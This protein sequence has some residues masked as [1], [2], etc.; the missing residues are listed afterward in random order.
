MIFALKDS[1]DR[2]SYNKHKGKIVASTVISSSKH[3][4]PEQT[5]QTRLAYHTGTAFPT[6][7]SLNP[8][9]RIPSNLATM[10]VMLGS[11]VASINS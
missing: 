5:M 6:D 2:E 10:K 9:P 7:I 8:S 4:W 1:W 11:F 3:M